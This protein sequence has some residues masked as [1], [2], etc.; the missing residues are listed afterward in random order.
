MLVGV[1]LGGYG[2][3]WIEFLAECY[4]WFILLDVCVCGCDLG[5]CC[6]S[7]GHDTVF[8]LVWIYV[9]KPWVIM[10]MCGIHVQ[11]LV[12]PTCAPGTFT[13]VNL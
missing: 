8:S 13:Q 7:V 10:F 3:R 9:T 12:F 11:N 2:G 1:S 4:C 6:E 5:F